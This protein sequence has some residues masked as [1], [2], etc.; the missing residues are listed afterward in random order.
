MN[1]FP[2]F[3]VNE[4]PVCEV[5][6]GWQMQGTLKAQLQSLT[7]QK[8]K[9]KLVLCTLHSAGTERTVSLGFQG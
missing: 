8:D 5:R 6:C 7:W 3:Q 1:I 4:L 2:A 9:R